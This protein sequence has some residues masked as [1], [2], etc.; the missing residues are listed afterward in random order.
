MVERFEVALVVLVKTIP[1]F[2]VILA[3]I[4]T[5]RAKAEAAVGLILRSPLIDIAPE[6]KVYVL[7][8][9]MVGDRVRMKKSIVP[10][11]KVTAA[12]GFITTIDVPAVKVPV[13]VN[14]VP[15]VPVR[16]MVEPLAVRVPATDRLAAVMA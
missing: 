9:V 16:V 8:S 13:R 5:V 15:E 2:T 4:F 11:V 12:F 10:E 3:P 14:S 6:P 1:P 7:L